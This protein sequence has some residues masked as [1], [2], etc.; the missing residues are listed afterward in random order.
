[1]K[2]RSYPQKPKR[3]KRQL[4]TWTFLTFQGA[5][6]FMFASLLERKHVSIP[7][8]GISGWRVIEHRYPTNG[9]NK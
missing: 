1:M 2:K 8:P 6:D 5:R 3:E 7:Y 9:V 4:V